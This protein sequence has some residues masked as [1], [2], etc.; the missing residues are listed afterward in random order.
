ME[1]LGSYCTSCSYDD[2]CSTSSLD[3][4]IVLH[5]CDLLS[6]GSCYVS[7]LNQASGPNDQSNLLRRA[8]MS[9]TIDV[10]AAAVV[11][12]AVAVV[13]LSYTDAIAV[14][15]CRQFDSVALLLGAFDDLPLPLPF[16]GMR[17]A[18]RA[19]PI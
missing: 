9:A 19:S 12:A 17:E 4:F 5:T 1:P 3:H 13:C 10:A 18:D 8:L 15:A 11:A 6:L 7:V 2:L 14:S 16:S